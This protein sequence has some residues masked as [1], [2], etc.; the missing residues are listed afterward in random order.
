MEW[1]NTAVALPTAEP[2]APAPRV[3]PYF[4]HDIGL[5]E[6]RE[7][8]NR[9]RRANPEKPHAAA[10]T[11]DALDRVLNQKGCV[12]GRFYYALNPD[13][14]PT[15]VLVGVDADGFDMDEGELAERFEP[16]PPFCSINSALDV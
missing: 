7:M 8:I 9:Y 3:W 15:L 5:T 11:R 4:E 16:C 10:V 14:T 13:G 12:G 2:E 6:A 1:Q